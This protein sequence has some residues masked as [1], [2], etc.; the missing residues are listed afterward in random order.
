MRV[1]LKKWMSILWVN[2]RFTC[3]GNFVLYLLFLLLLIM[4]MIMVSRVALLNPNSSLF[5]I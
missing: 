2:V 5:L 3:G 4:M 1:L